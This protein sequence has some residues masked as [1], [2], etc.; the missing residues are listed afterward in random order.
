MSQFHKLVISE[1]HKETETCITIAFQ[2]PSELKEIFKFKAG[3]Y[4]TLKATIEGKELRRDYSICASPHS[5]NLRVAVKSVAD[6]TFSL[7]ANTKL[8]VC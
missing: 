4:I 2:I 7:Y 8:K 5:G 6:G 1:L 3:Q